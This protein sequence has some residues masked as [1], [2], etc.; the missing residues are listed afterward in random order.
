MTS[1]PPD[2]HADEILRRELGKL[3]SVSGSIGGR[4]GGGAAGAAGGALGGR[5]GA[6][7]AARYLSN[8]TYEASVDV[9]GDPADA[10]MR[11]FEALLSVGSITEPADGPADGVEHPRLV[12]VVGAGFFNMNPALVEVDVEPTAADGSRVTVR[13]TAKEGLIKQRTAEKA[14]RRVVD[15]LADT[16]Q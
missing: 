14:V 3:G 15:R 1:P 5:L 12:A 4:I 16:P 10:V 8:E 6:E 2:P 11:C 13:A 7:W 9:T